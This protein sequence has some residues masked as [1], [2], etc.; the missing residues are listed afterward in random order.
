MKKALLIAMIIV[1]AGTAVAVSAK[2]FHSPPKQ[3]G[4]LPKA[5][6]DA[7]L[8]NMRIPFAPYEIVFHV[9][10]N[11]PVVKGEIRIDDKVLTVLDIKEKNTL[12]A[13]RFT[14]TPES[15]GE[16]LIEARG[17]NEAGVWGDPA[18]A[19]VYVG[20][21]TPT[22]TKTPAPTLTPTNTPTPT[23][24][25]T[26]EPTPT[27]EKATFARDPIFD[28]S[29]IYFGQAC[30]G[31]AEVWASVELTST[32]DVR[33]ISIFYKLTSSTGEQ[34]EWEDR[35]MNP[36]GGGV[37]TLTINPFSSEQYRSWAWDGNWYS[38]STGYMTTQFVITHTDGSY[39]RSPI[40]NLVNVRSCGSL[41]P[42][43][44]PPPTPTPTYR[45]R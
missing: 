20:A 36:K 27:P 16:Y 31:T 23:P 35:A 13:L 9:S 40:Y 19:L 12:Y 38:S 1:V 42:T 22:P 18:K 5:W 30:F 7:P 6:I 24:T 33:L 29:D 37:Y 28:P 43:Q 15:E 39:S 3:D 21:A 17:Q 2:V 25:N 14:W 32:Q 41:A 26:P 8:N 44:P 11:S 45:V 34:G 4:S 10:S